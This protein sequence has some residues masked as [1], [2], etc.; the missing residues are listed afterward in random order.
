M[1]EM[2]SQT[3]NNEVEAEVNAHNLEAGNDRSSYII[4]SMHVC[5]TPIFDIT[6]IFF[7]LIF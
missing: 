6:K 3:F 1:I 7:L 4:L 2:D 5:H